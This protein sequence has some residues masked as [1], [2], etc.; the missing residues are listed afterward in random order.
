MTRPTSS[1]SS[2]AVTER[3]VPLLRLRGLRRRRG[4]G[5]RPHPPDPQGDDADHPDRRGLR[6]VV[7][8]RVRAGRA[9]PAGA[10]STATI[11]D[12][13]PSILEDSL[14]TVRVQGL[15]VIAVTAFVSC[16]LSLQAAGSRLLYS[17]AR[18]RML[19]MSGWLSQMSPSGTRCPTNALLVACVVPILICLYVYGDPDQLAR[20]TVVRRAGHLRRVPGGRPRGAAPAASRAGVRPGT[21][22]WAP[23]GCWSTSWR[24]RT[25]IMAMYLL[26]K[27]GDTG[28][29]LD[30]DW[31]VA[32][33]LAVVMGGDCCTCSSPSPTA[34]PR[35]SPRVTP[36]RSRNWCGRCASNRETRDALRRR[37]LP[38]L[39]ACMGDHSHVGS[40][41]RRGQTGGRRSKREGHAV[42]SAQRNA[43][44]PVIA[45]PTTRVCISTVPS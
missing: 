42:V 31:I 14:G 6:L 35:A 19:P 34:T 25:A 27:P 37:P 38:T 21:G 16:V 40:P 15:P 41:H 2:A 32:I 3:A 9:Q 23:R 28:K 12:P 13:I 26:L 43:S 45:W 8:R 36:S 4:G 7:V 44:R 20:V 10:S 33:G 22:T 1:P 11:A 5:R 17:S 30:D 29:F 39:A 18:D 24:R